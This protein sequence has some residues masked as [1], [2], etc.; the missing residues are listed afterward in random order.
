MCA[1]FPLHAARVFSGYS[2]FGK[3]V[4][5]GQLRWMMRAPL[6]TLGVNDQL[7]CSVKSPE[8]TTVIVPQITADGGGRIVIGVELKPPTCG[9]GRQQSSGG[10][11][12][13]RARDASCRRLM[14]ATSV[15]YVLRSDRCRKAIL[16][17][18]EEQQRENFTSP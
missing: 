7:S 6:S 15:L 13:R 8:A 3:G 14:A 9:D 18:R 2:S 16:R 12:G 11:A 5:C 17:Y 4:I 1:R 10:D